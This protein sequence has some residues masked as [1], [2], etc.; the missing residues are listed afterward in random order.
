QRHAS[1]LIRKCKPLA[2]RPCK[3]WQP[4]LFRAM[5]V[6][7][8]NLLKTWSCFPTC[9]SYC[10]LTLEK[11]ATM[12]LHWREVF[13]H[14]KETMKCTFCSYWITWEETEKRLQKC[15]G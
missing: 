11:A 12:H 10:P 3:S 13:A 6:N 2:R 4:G 14:S 8:R 1:G 7:W 15:W 5:S 9:P